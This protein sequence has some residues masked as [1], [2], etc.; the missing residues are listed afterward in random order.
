MPQKTDLATVLRNMM[1][2]S[3]SDQFAMP[4]SVQAPAAMVEKLARIALDGAERST[5][6]AVD[7]ASRTLAMMSEMTGAHVDPAG[8]AKSVN[9]FASNYV[10]I[11]SEAM[12]ALAETVKSVQME[13]VEFLMM[14]SQGA[15]AEIPQTLKRRTTSAY[16]SAGRV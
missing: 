16:V 1:G 13:S 9:D 11:A 8:Y 4:V 2:A 14:A 10:E 3:S 15:A 7:L 12:A 5:H 6:I